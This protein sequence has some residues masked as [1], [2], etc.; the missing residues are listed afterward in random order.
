MI[1]QNAEFRGIREEATDFNAGSIATAPIPKQFGIAHHAGGKNRLPEPL[2]SR[3]GGRFVIL[4]ENLRS[5]QNRRPLAEAVAGDGAAS[6]LIR[7]HCFKF[8]DRFEHMPVKEAGRLARRIFHCRCGFPAFPVIHGYAEHLLK[9]TDRSMSLEHVVGVFEGERRLG[10]HCTAVCRKIPD[11][12]RYFLRH[13]F[14]CRQQQQTVA[15][16][17]V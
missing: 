16:Q 11:G 3:R 13:I 5:G 7:N 8:A 10:N 12:I 14:D 4:P 1:Q 15:F 9:T 17:F 2:H 6:I